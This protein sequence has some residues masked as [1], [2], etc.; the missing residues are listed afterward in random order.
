LQTNY[1][2]KLAN[3]FAAHNINADYSYKDLELPHPSR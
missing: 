3:L 1:T 2:Q